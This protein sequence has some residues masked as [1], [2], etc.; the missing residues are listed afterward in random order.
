MKRIGIVR[1]Q[2]SYRPYSLRRS[3]QRMLVLLSEPSNWNASV[4]AYL[5]AGRVAE[6]EVLLDDKTWLA[7]RI[8]RG[9]FTSRL[10][11]LRR[12]PCLSIVRSEAPYLRDSHDIASPPTQHTRRPFAHVDNYRKHG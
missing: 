5:A 7:C 3:E 10:F 12:L 11:S 8:S 4:A 2:H 1:G 6:S 9:G